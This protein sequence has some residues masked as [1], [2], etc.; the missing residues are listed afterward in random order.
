MICSLSTTCLSCTCQVSKEES[1]RIAKHFKA[2]F[3]QAFY[4]S[5]IIPSESA[6]LNLVS[7]HCELIS[8]NNKYSIGPSLMM[9]AYSAAKLLEVGAS[10]LADYPDL[11]QKTLDLVMPALVSLNLTHLF[12]HRG[13]LQRYNSH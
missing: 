1:H 4:A 11:M 9:L 10:K 13:L 2:S 5:H 3:L 6:V 8:A 7:S 12:K